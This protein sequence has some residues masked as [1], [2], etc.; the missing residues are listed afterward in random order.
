MAFS[1]IAD[2]DA[3][4]NEMPWAERSLPVTTFA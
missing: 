4:H 1:T 2:R 3:I